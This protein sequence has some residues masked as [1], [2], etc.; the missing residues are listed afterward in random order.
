MCNELHDHLE[1]TG[2]NPPVLRRIQA[3]SEQIETAGATQ[4]QKLWERVRVQD[5]KADEVLVNERTTQE[6]TSQRQAALKQN[7]KR[8]RRKIS[9]NGKA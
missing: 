8:A 2:A 1:K 4:R 6:C 3:L 5:R 7:V 9:L